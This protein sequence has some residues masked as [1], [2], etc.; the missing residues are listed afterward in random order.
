MQPEERL[1]EQNRIVK[2]E[3]LVQKKYNVHTVVVALPE[4]A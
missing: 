2:I 3:H 1:A 4:P